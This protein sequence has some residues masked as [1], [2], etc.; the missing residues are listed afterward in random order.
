MLE[1]GSRKITVKARGA[2]EHDRARQQTTIEPDLAFNLD[3]GGWNGR[4]NQSVAERPQR[5]P[6]LCPTQSK[7]TNKTLVTLPCAKRQY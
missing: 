5:A 6:K 7:V 4:G 1:D 2:V 3:I